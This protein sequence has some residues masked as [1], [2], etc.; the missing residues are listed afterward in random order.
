RSPDGDAIG[1]ILAIYNFITLNFPDKVVFPILPDRCPEYLTFLPNSDKFL[2]P[3]EHIEIINQAFNTADII[4]AVDFNES[5][6]LGALENLFF[7]SKA[8][9]IFI[10]HHP[11]TNDTNYELLFHD[12]N[13][14]AASELVYYVLKAIGFESF[15]YDIVLPIYVGIITDTGSLSFNCNLP[16]TYSVLSEIIKYN[17]DAKNIHNL[18][19]NNFP[20]ERMKLFAH[21][22][23]NKLV[24]NVDKKYSYYSLTKE[25]LE[26]FG[27]RDGYLEGVVNY[28]LNI[29][30]IEVTAAFVELNNVV[31]ISFRSKNN[32][33]V[34]EIAKTYFNGGGHK[35]AAGAN[36][37][38]SINDAIELFVEVIESI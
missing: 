8:H 15:N 27:Y 34:N 17:I 14:S 29:R 11:F 31:K 13:A 38:K 18:I 20:V 21:V 1:S 26:E 7:I 16:Q 5:N 24:I 25:E 22:L 28:A 4:I 6:R 23:Y 33:N 3:D 37:N 10:D 36:Y 32:I 2:N 30:G 12:E 9:K 35:N 19:Y